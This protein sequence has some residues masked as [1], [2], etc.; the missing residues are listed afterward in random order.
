MDAEDPAQRA[1]LHAAA[2][3]LLD[4]AE[5]YYASAMAGLSALPPR[6]AWAIAAA[7]RIYRAIGLKLRAGAGCLGAPGL[8]DEARKAAPARARARRCRE[9]PDGRA[10]APRTGLWQRPR[11]Q[12]P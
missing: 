9:K 2:L 11:P 12:R 5:R 4:L 1:A 10:G 7:R 6:S 3:D 8:D